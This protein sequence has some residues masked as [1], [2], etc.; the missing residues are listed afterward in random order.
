[1][2]FFES[3]FLTMTIVIIIINT[4][5]FDLFSGY[6][7]IK[8]YLKS[9]VIPTVFTWSKK[10][11]QVTFENPPA[12]VNLPE[13]DI[14]NNEENIHAD[15]HAGR[16]NKEIKSDDINEFDSVC[17]FEEVAVIIKSDSLRK[18][19]DDEVIT[20]AERREEICQV[21]AVNS[22]CVDTLSD[23]V[24]L[25]IDYPEELLNV[26]AHNDQEILPVD[27]EVLPQENIAPVVTSVS[28]LKRYSIEDFVDNPKAVL[29]FT[30]LESYHKFI[31]VFT[32]LGISR[33]FGK[34]KYIS[35]NGCGKLSLQ[36]QLFLTW[37]KMRKNATDMELSLHF[38]IQ[39]KQVGN[40][41]RSWIL[42][43]KKQWSKVD[44]WPC[45][46][47]IEF[48]MPSNFKANYPKTRVIIDGTEFKVQR[49][50]NPLFQQ[51]S[52]SYYKNETTL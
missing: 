26:T 5:F 17:C 15:D 11:T 44:V 13:I 19:R 3:I 33:G 35:N 1:M 24:D 23:L 28:R 2:D 51:S 4:F 36:N 31:T 47:L 21:L 38:G 20:D 25:S 27:D 9:G 29:E 34:L 32:S 37:W 22:K 30:G 52:F 18:D 42:F 50:K 46:E 45:K 48:Y 12:P 39:E 10:S 14:L 49:N 7:L 43:M 16:N 8:L 40:I 41:C 6:D